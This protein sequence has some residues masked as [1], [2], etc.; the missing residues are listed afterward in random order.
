MITT[1]DCHVITDGHAAA[2]A[3][4]A[5]DDDDGGGGG[6]CVGAVG[7][8]FAVSCDNLYAGNCWSV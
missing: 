4:A 1:T 5:D 2:A 3:A 7:G 8:C 6:G